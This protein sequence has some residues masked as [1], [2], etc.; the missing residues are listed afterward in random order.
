MREL[1]IFVDESGSDGL[2]DRYYLLTVVM[3]DQSDSIAESTKAYEDALCAKG[4][5]DI[6]FHASPLMN[7]KDQH[8]GLDLRT[9]KMML[10]SF[11][12]F[13]RHMPVRYRTFAYATK[14]FASLDRLAG[15]MRRDIVNFLFD[16]LAELQSY[17]MVKVYYDNG[18]RSIAESLHR[19][20]EYAL[21]KDAV[22]YRSV[23]PSECRLSQAADYV[24]AMELTAIK[25]ADHA[26]TTT[27]EKFFGKWS[28]FK[29]GILKE[30]PPPHPRPAV[31]F[32]RD[33]NEQVFGV[34]NYLKRMT[35]RLIVFIETYLAKRI[36]AGGFIGSRS[37][38]SWGMRKRDKR[39][40]RH[41][42]PYPRTPEQHLLISPVVARGRAR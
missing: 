40:N 11:R 13:F 42:L 5:P 28:D 25:N 36:V 7:G 29:K 10:G 24:C 27:D 18:Q 41:W 26:A 2:S 20:V 32:P 8:S 34:R 9:R 14:Q 3:H 15:A 30:T 33:K 4:L 38:R 31:S 22:V 39:K 1:S 21:S 23:Q 35:K 17:D 37:C 19:A 6:P 16:N 12:V